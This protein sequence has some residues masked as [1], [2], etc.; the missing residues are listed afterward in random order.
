MEHRTGPL[1]TPADLERALA[2]ARRMLDG[3]EH[4]GPAEAKRFDD[5]LRRISEYRGADAPPPASPEHQKLQAL[6]GQ[7]KAFGRRWGPGEGQDRPD[8]WRFM[9]G[10]DVNPKRSTRG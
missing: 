9:F 1:R 4:A 2:E 7:L 5:L 3:L 8:H 10:G 6:D